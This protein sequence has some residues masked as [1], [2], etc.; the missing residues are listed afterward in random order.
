[1]VS[2]SSGSADVLEAIGVPVEAEPETVESTIERAGIGFLLAPVF[3]PAMKS[4]IGPRQELGMRTV[5]NVLGPLTNPAGADAQ[6]LG[7]YD[8]A[9]VGTIARALAHMPVERALVV[10]GSGIDEIAIHE[11]TTVAEVSGGRVEEYKLV[12]EDLG[13]NRAPI[14]AIAG[15]SPSAN[16]RDLRAILD[17]ELTG[18][19]RDVV[20]ANAGA[21][22]YVAGEAASLQDG[23]ETARKAIEDGEAVAQLKAL[24]AVPAA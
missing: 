8:V 3:H 4:V 14:E 12:P 7:V 2:S 13:L 1:S 24:T 16:A 9:L 19:K 17:G 22:I 21:A 5:F 18:P 11:T 20:L 23:V 6:V 15:G 10:H